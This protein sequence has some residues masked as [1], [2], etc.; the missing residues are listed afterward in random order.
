[1]GGCFDDEDD[2]EDSDEYGFG[3][4]ED[5]D[6]DDNESESSSGEDESDSDGLEG[7]GEQGEEEEEE[8]G[9]EEEGDRG[10][11]KEGA[12]G[13]TEA[14]G[15]AEGKPELNQ[16]PGAARP[17]RSSMKG[18]TQ[19]NVPLDN[20]HER[21]SV[22]FGNS[23][24]ENDGRADTAGGDPSN[25]NPDEQISAQ[26]EKPAKVLP[27][28]RISGPI[29]VGTLVLPQRPSAI[30]RSPSLEPRASGQRLLSPRPLAEDT[31][32]EGE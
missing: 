11:A 27:Y 15:G 24:K 14:D 10:G 25:D 3:N 26:A 20:G 12:E 32:D 6:D 17:Q 22:R 16:F 8:A 13:V 4:M 2:D 29:N 1:M 30:K 9:E 19:Q 5:G 18:G 28:R 21:R 31:L 23:A 7:D